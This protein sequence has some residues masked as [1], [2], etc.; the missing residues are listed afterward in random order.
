MLRYSDR[1]PIER[2]TLE[3]YVRFALA[4]AERAGAA[5]LPFFRADVVID[6]KRDDGHFDPVTEADRAAE[7]VFRETLRATYPEHGIFGEEYG[8]NLICR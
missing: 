4:V 8:W 2:R 3:E 6:N 5:T 1:V 7:Q